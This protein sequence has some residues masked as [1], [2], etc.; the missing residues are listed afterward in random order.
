VVRIVADMHVSMRTV[1]ALRQL[2]HDVTRVA[3]V[4]APTATDTQIVDEAIRDDRV[5]LTQD[6][7][8]SALV[9]VSGR[10]V[11]SVVSLRLSSA[12]VET[13]NARLT[14]VL[15]MLEADLAAGAIAVV[16]DLRVRTR[17]LP[18]R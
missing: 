13:V 4:L 10:S 2:G 12:R 8:F 11:P 16:E 18:V 7:D 3:D 6:L 14:R 17:K 15:P 9:A 5:I 1:E